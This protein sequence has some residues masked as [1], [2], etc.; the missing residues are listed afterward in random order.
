MNESGPLIDIQDKEE[1]D[2]KFKELYQKY[3]YMLYDAA[4]FEQTQKNLDEVFDEAC[5]IYQIVYEKAARFKKAGKCGFVWNV[6]GRALC[7][8]YALETEGDKVLVP[9]TVARNLAKKR[10]R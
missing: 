9:L 3:K 4:E 1:T 2:L 5:T 8:F 10:R 7:R 6:A